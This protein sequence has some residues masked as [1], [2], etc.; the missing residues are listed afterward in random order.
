MNLFPLKKIRRDVKQ[1]VWQWWSTRSVFQRAGV[2]LCKWHCPY[3]LTS[4]STQHI[5]MYSHIESP[6]R[7][8]IFYFERYFR[9]IINLI[10]KKKLSKPANL[11][12]WMNHF[13]LFSSCRRCCLFLS[14]LLCLAQFSLCLT[15]NVPTG[16]FAWIW[17]WQSHAFFPPHSCMSI[18]V[19]AFFLYINAETYDWKH[20]KCKTVLQYTSVV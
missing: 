3:L 6:T 2:I 8:V 16:S 20:D 11:L 15:T 14:F 12:Y 13:M 10:E 17:S 19:E 18:A 5:S 4:I 1:H 9:H 7:L